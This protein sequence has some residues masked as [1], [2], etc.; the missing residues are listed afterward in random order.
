MSQ[1]RPL[2]PR[3]VHRG[4]HLTR[5]QW[6]APL[7]AVA[8]LGC[9]EGGTPEVAVAETA[10]VTPAPIVAPAPVLTPAQVAS[11]DAVRETMVVPTMTVVTPDLTLTPELGLA[12]PEVLDEI[13]WPETFQPPVP[14]LV[15]TAYAALGDA[16][17]TSGEHWYAVSLPV[18][19]GVSVYVSGTRQRAER[20]ADRDE[21]LGTGYNPVGPNTSSSHSV[22]TV[23][24]MAYGIAYTLDV[25]CSAGGI[26]DRCADDTMALNIYDSLVRVEGIR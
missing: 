9:A 16:T 12:A 23:H 7:A 18:V 2:P 5:P 4:T 21:L 3:V 8:L 11:D 26:D 10:V 13:T 20:P 17:W 24:F 14:V 25:E 22:W 1:P 19:D 6:I 15:P